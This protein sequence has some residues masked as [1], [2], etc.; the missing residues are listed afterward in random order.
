MGRHWASHADSGWS[1]G[2]GKGWA[3]RNEDVGMNFHTQRP[4]AAVSE[5]D[6]RGK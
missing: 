4:E 2:R 6:P 1:Q 3:R 5:W